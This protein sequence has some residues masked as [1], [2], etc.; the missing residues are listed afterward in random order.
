M[1]TKPLQPEASASGES[2]VAIQA[3]E[4]ERLT[5]KVDKLEKFILRMRTAFRMFNLPLTPLK[6]QP[7]R[8][9]AKRM[10]RK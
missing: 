1:N 2:V 7:T 8:T 6:P 3:R 9:P 5:T 4:I 10:R